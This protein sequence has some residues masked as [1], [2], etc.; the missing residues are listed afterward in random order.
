MPIRHISPGTARTLNFLPK[1]VLVRKF[2]QHVLALKVTFCF[3]SN[4]CT[5]SVAGSFEQSKEHGSDSAN[6]LHLTDGVDAAGHGNGRADG[7]LERVREFLGDGGG[8][9]RGT[10]FGDDSGRRQLV[11]GRRA[12]SSGDRRDATC[13]VV[14]M[15]RVCGLKKDEEM[16]GDS[17]LRGVKKSLSRKHQNRFGVKPCKNKLTMPHARRHSAFF[18]TVL[19]WTF[20][21]GSS[22]NGDASCLQKVF[23]NEFRQ[24]VGIVGVE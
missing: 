15:K 5:S 4:A 8:K 11:D 22:L 23:V 6:V 24:S 3:C 13:S 9:E 14:L 21:E 12:S 7:L 20:S 18:L 16:V 1:M 2:S 17:R 10:S 19:H